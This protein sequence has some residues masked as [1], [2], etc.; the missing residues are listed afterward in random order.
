MWCPVAIE[1]LEHGV[2]VIV[3]QCWLP[4]LLGRGNLVPELDSL[5]VDLLMQSKL[6]S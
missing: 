5:F 1:C 4:P 3:S 6:E 2:T